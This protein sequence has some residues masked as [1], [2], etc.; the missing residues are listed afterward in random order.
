MCMAP[1][2]ATIIT[3][4]TIRTTTRTR[5]MD[6]TSP[7][8]RRLRG[9]AAAALAVAG[10]SGRLLRLFAWARMGGGGGRHR[11]RRD[12]CAR[13]SIDLLHFGAPR[14]DAILFACAFCAPRGAT[15]RALD[16]VN[17][18]AVALA[19]SA[20]RR[21]ETTAQG[22]AFVAAMRAAWGCPALDRLP[23]N[24]G[25]ACRLSYR[26]RRRCRGPRT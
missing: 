22:A 23:G 4:T 24:G 10:L 7:E 11:R 18:L 15:G 13:G 6:A 19:G 17:A 5:L 14:T 9:T 2:A 3:I 21:L 16:E 8:P 26:G 25:R 20:E 12:A 1:T